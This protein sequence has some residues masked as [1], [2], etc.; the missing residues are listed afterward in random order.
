MSMHHPRDDLILS[1]SAGGLGESWSLAIAAHLALCPVCRDDVSLAEEIGG[2]LLEDAKV[3]PAH[4]LDWDEILDRL[5]DV[6]SD[7]PHDK[8]FSDSMF[9]HPLRDYIGVGKEQIPWRMIG[10][11]VGQHLIETG[12]SGQARLLKIPAGTALP[13]HGHSGRELTLVLSG[14]YKDGVE[15]FA[16]G[17]MGDVDQNSVH[18]PIAG[19]EGECI[20]LVVTDSPV[21]FKTLLPKIAQP[22]IKI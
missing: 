1:Y 18:R 22:F 7:L 19:S 13:E 2:V 11:G 20:T 16:R 3:D 5:D 12:D 10:D 21:K 6:G 17:D 15:K 4:T 8:K 9:P 14:S